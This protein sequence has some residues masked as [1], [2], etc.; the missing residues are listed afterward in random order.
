[1]GWE[2]DANAL[3]VVF[4]RSIPSFTLQNL[5]EAVH[6][7]LERAKISPSEVARFVCH[8]GGAKVV[9]AIE[10]ALDLEKGTLAAERDVLRDFGN[11][12]APTV[13]FVLDRVIAAGA[14]GQMVLSALGP[15]FT[16]SLLPLRIS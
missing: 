13:L 10:E 11:M 9:S 8:P 3:G 15:G 14:K 12:S 7:A 4:D 6:N 2:V 1:M 16:A 5:A